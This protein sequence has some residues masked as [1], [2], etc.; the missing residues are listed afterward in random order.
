MPTSYKCIK[1]L[2]SKLGQRPAYKSENLNETSAL[3]IK[4]RNK[5]IR[6][7]PLGVEG[8]RNSS[9]IKSTCCFVRA[10]SIPSTHI[11]TS[12]LSVTPVPEDPIVSSNF[13]IHVVN[14]HIH[15]GKTLIHMK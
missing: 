14:I 12:Q 15:S 4:V 7:L 10:S 9:E 6:P 1:T 11:T 3:H 2:T 5:V 13:C 8:R